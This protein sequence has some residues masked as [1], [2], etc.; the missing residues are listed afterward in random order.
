[1]GGVELA[2]VGVE[3][4]KGWSES[5]RGKR[6]LIVRTGMCIGRLMRYEFMIGGQN[7]LALVPVDGWAMGVV[8]R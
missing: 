3:G 5:V 8:Q 1:M 7:G 6:P 4:S 2:F